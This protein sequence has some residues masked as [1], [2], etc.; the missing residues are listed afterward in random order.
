MIKAAI[1]LLFHTL[2]GIYGQ[3]TVPKF[4]LNCNPGC[5]GLLWKSR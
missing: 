5:A 2:A 4:S 3:R 1:C